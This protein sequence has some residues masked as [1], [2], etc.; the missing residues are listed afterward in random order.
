MF[1]L[2]VFILCVCV[3]VLSAG[4]LAPIFA[5]KKPAEAEE[6]APVENPELVRKRREFLMSGVPTE[7]TRPAVNASP[8]IVASEPAPFPEISH[9]QQ[10]TSSE[11]GCLD[12]WSLRAVEKIQA[13]LR[14]EFDP[15]M[16]A[17]PLLGFKW[18]SL[19]WQP[20]SPAQGKSVSLLQVCFFC[21]FLHKQS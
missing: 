21:F 2:W 12:V 11:S 5:K 9:V 15:G 19:Q 14:P 6:S 4:K 17:A 16:D 18:E 20:T 13:M 1:F 8:A 3:C 7:L 10:R